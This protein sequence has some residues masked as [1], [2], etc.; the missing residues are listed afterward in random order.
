MKSHLLIPSLSAAHPL[1]TSPRR[2]SS[3]SAS[4]SRH[5]AASSDV[6]ARSSRTCFGSSTVTATVSGRAGAA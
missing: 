1:E 4:C 2:N 3:I 6:G 5:A